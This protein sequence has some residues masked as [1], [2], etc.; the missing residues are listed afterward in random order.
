MYNN[1]ARI[2]FGWMILITNPSYLSDRAACLALLDD[3]SEFYEYREFMPVLLMLLYRIFLCLLSIKFSGYRVNNFAQN[4]N[5]K[6]VDKKISNL[7]KCMCLEQK[8]VQAIQ[9]KCL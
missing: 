3:R 7:F 2:S 5:L 8:I 9:I 1:C 4:V 6:P